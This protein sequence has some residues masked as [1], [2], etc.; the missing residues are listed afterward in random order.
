MTTPFCK[1]VLVSCVLATA[2]FASAAHARVRAYVT[3][4]LSNTVSVVDVSTHTVVATIPVGARPYGSAVSPQGDRAF[5]TNAEGD[6]VS[7]IDTATSTVIATIPV[8][9]APRSVAFTPDGAK[10]YVTNRV[11][12][13]SV[14][15]V[16]TSTQVKSIAG[17]VYPAGI[18]VSPD[19]T[20]AYVANQAST[21]VTVIDTANETVLARIS[22]P[23]Q[24]WGI[25]VS[26]DGSNVYVLSQYGDRIIVVDARTDTV[27]H[28]IPLPSN[29]PDS[30]GFGIALSPDGRFAYVT[31]GGSSTSLFTVD[32]VS[33]SLR[34]AMIGNGAA[35]G[36][37]VDPTGCFVYVAT[38]GG[39]KVYDP[40]T[41]KVVASLLTGEAPTAFGKF[42]GAVS[43][44]S[45]THAVEEAI[46]LA[47][48]AGSI[49]SAVA[50]LLLDSLTP[51][52]EKLA[53]IAANPS[54]PDLARV[55]NETCTLINAFNAQMDH[56]VRLRR[57]PANLRD[58]WKADMLE[59]KADLGCRS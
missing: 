44:P 37:D 20:R 53:W 26:P 57:L 54:S 28:T 48:D 24:P 43:A 15:N 30:R 1:T 35:Q 58:Q 32:L 5:V 6:S 16:P 33:G 25:A 27:A 41:S 23:T 38:G 14:I 42:I 9:D 11:G 34:T 31:N 13:I 46:V 55:K 51:I 7:V 4:Q 22:M 40:A 3:N 2:A 59:V 39:V 18:A 29:L 47:M 19:G 56:Y 12:G 17:G 50:N 36:V 10:A 8:G 21:D 45:G 49:S 52:Q